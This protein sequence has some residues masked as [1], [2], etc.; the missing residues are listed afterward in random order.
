MGD[1][2]AAAQWMQNS[3]EQVS[4]KQRREHLAQLQIQLATL[5]FRQGREP[6]ALELFRQGIDGADRAGDPGLCANA[7]NRLGEELLKND[8]TADA[9][10]ALLEA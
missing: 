1:L 9:E 5:R 3:L 2:D 6:E 10:H 4:G 8:R 7:W